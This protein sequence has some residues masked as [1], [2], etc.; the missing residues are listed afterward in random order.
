MNNAQTGGLKPIYKYVQPEPHNVHKVPVPR[1]P[2]ETE[3]IICREMAFQQADPNHSQH[4]CAQKHMKAV[5]TCQH[6]K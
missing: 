5:T 1:S 3:V 2:F 6:K 4:C